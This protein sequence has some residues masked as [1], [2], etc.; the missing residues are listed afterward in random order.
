MLVVTGHARTIR[1]SKG[2]QRVIR[3]TYVL[4]QGPV[5]Q[6][7]H[8]AKQENTIMLQVRCDCQQADL[9]FPLESLRLVPPERGLEYREVL[10]TQLLR[11]GILC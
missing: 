7:V 6:T 4:K 11:I 1:I 2:G 5:R 8:R 9:P 10:P 3:G